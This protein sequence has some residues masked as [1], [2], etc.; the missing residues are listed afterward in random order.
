MEIRKYQKTTNLLPAKSAFKRL[1]KE[2]T[3]DVRKEDGGDDVRY[4]L[5]A[6]DALQ[7]ASEA[8][9]TE[10]FEDANLHA[11]HAKRV[12]ITRKDLLLAIRKRRLD[13]TILSG[14]KTTGG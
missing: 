8:L 11:L 12:T 1:V 3:D 2:V 9:I 13:E 4:R 10:L 14:V 6:I 5:E 7:W